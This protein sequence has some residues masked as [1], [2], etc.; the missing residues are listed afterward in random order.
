MKFLLKS[1]CFAAALTFSLSTNAQAIF[2]PGLY[3]TGEPLKKPRVMKPFVEFSKARK[4][5]D[6]KIKNLKGEPI[7]LE[8]LKGKLVILNVWATWCTP[9]IREIPQLAE[10]QKKLAGTNIELVGVSIDA[11]PAEVEGFLKKQKQ[12][13]FKTWFDPTTSV[14][15]VMP[16]EVVP[17]SFLLDAKGNLIGYLPGFLPWDDPTILPFLKELEKKYATVT[18]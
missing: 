6:L 17:T 9:C 8:S 11:N 1:L 18:K 15:A 16:M 13:D 7:N 4:M 3:S 2:S 10:L 12:T 14:E 5:P